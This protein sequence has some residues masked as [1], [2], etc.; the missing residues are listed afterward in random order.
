MCAHTAVTFSGITKEF[1]FLIEIPGKIK[2]GPCKSVSSVQCVTCQPVKGATFVL[3]LSCSE[4]PERF[5][6]HAMSV[7]LEKIVI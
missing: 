1:A 3:Q 2:R 4:V 5:T 7:A 6:P